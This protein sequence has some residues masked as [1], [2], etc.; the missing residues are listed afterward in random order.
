MDVQPQAATSVASNRRKLLDDRIR[1]IRD[2]VDS[3]IRNFAVSQFRSFVPKGEF[4][5][6]RL[7]K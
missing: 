3:L 4:L 5:C 6:R 2:F 1:L 7:K